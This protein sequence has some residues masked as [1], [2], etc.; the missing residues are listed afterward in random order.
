MFR[1]RK[2]LNPYLTVNEQEIEQVQA[3]IQSQFPDIAKE[4]ITTIPD[5]LINP[6][7]YQYKTLL[8]IADDHHGRV[9]G[10]ALLLYMPDLSFCYLDFLAVSPGRTSSGVGGALYER[11]REEADSMDATGLFME[12]LP[13]DP[14]NCPDNEI[15][16]Q[17]S[18]RLAFYERYGARPVIGTQYETPVK[19]GDTCAPF[20]VFDGLGSHEVTDGR[21]LRAIVEAILERKYGDYCPKEYIRQVVESIGDNPIR[22]RPFRY[23]RRK[24]NERFETALSERRKIFWVINDRHKI[25]HVRER[26][27]VE[28]P[29]RV[30]TIRKALLPTGWFKL[31][32]SAS[33]PEKFIRD[34]HNT[35]YLN[36]FKKVCRN[37]PAGKSLYP[38]VFP[39]RNGA[40]P[41]KDLSVRA[42]YY[43]I[44]TFTP[45]NK[46]AYL[47]A[48]HGVNCTL[49][50][51][52]AL[53]S[54][55]SLAYVLT[56]P[57]GHHAEHN[58]FGGFCYFNNSAIAAQ[59]LSQL[60][61]VALL[62]IDYHHGNGQQQIF[63]ERNDVLTISIHGH[64]SFAYPYFS[65]FL[66]EK[67]K[68]RGEGFN[69]NFPLGEEISAEVYRQ[70][71]M[72][73]LHIIRQYNPV[74]LIVPLGFDTAKD[75]PTG[76]WK[77]TAADFGQNGFL[78]GQLKIPTLFTQEGG[79]YNRRL[80]TNAREFFR[81]VQKG[82]FSDQ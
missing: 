60:G 13:D 38:Y 72:K 33:Y 71:L 56:R 12:C 40:K 74:H 69:Y 23:T 22:L 65:G 36:Y 81:G 57:P 67:G 17:N 79:Y 82:F 59:Y 78:I 28:S 46:N 70:T 63:Y 11:V 5:Q 76:T 31:E 15:R 48:R 6:L 16:K 47:A 32:S 77:L 20:L 49:T 19:P 3:I 41:P 8:F 21:I 80:G 10:C 54:G 64:P 55:H 68:N 37:L 34:V 58:V 4:K 1:I 61:R 18:K 51:A 53:L 42:G 45:L 24:D 9:K 27:Y 35:G 50:A 29:V 25:H 2:I 73:T 7:K 30:D 66:R 14:A 52:D 26:G 75:D 43:C 62:D 39:I 44:D